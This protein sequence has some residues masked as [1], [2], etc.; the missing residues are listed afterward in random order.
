VDGRVGWKS[1]ERTKCVHVT[2]CISWMVVGVSGICLF[3][4]DTK[5]KEDLSHRLKIGN[6]G[7]GAWSSG[8]IALRRAGSALDNDVRMTVAYYGVWDRYRLLDRIR[9]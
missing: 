3:G 8:G 6:D 5:L 2:D 4:I 9:W 7:C 1:V